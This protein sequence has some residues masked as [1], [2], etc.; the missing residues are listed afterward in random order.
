[1]T[2][3]SELQLNAL[4]YRKMH[5]DEFCAAALSVN[6]MEIVDGWE[7]R[8]RSAYAIFEKDGNRA[9]LIQELASVSWV[10][11]LRFQEAIFSSEF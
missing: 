10:L 1:M 8:A 11:F 2:E 9:I 7:E 5:L 4:G 3:A 6:Q